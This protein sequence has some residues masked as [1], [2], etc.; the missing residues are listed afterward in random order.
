[1]INGLYRIFLFVD[2]QD[3]AKEFWINTMGFELHHDTEDCPGPR[4]V[5]VK[6]PDG[7]II[8]L[9]PRPDEMPS[10]AGQMS[11]VAF[12]CADLQ[13]TYKELLDRGVEF[14]EEPHEAHWGLATMFKDPDGT[15]F[16]LSQGAE[17]ER[18]TD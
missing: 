16:N 5:E 8:L 2:D 3:K 14:T 10:T 15:L 4:W 7:K 17:Y 6:A 13:A 9:Q 12:E 18:Q 11:Y 1:M